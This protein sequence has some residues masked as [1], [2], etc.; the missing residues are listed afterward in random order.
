MEP[1]PAEDPTKAKS[2][3]KVTIDKEKLLRL[4][5]DDDDSDLSSDSDVNTSAANAASSDEG[6]L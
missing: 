3:S 5:N 1:K 6:S 4:L 2:G